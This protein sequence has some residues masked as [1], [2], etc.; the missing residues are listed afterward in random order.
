MGDFTRRSLIKSLGAAGAASLFGPLIL[1]ATVRAKASGRV[2]VIGGGFGGATCAKYARRYAPGI[3]VTLVERGAKYV[4]CPFS[5]TVLGGLNDMDFITHGYDKLQSK[6]GIK[7]VNDTVT[8]VDPAA[9]K[10]ELKGGKSLSYD[11]LVVSPGIAFRW[12]EIEG[13][14]EAASE[15]MPHAWKAGPQTVL[16]RKQIEAM[17]DGG[18]VI[19][20]PPAGPF[21]APSAPYERASMIAYYLK[22]NKPKSKVLIVDSRD[23]FDEK[24]QFKGAWEKLYPGMIELVRASYGG[25]VQKADPSTMTV[26]AKAGES[27]K[28]NVINVIPPQRAGEIAHAAGLVDDDGWCPVD[29]KTFESAK[30]K[31]IHVIGDS[32]IAGDMPKAASA[33]STQGK[34]CA[35]AIVSSLSG[36]PMPDPLHASVFYSLLDKRYGISN[37]HLYRL[38]DGR[39]KVVSGGPSPEKASKKFRRREAE[40]ANSWYAAI[41]ADTFG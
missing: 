14:D 18:V 17:E 36:T 29:Q 12:G 25:M 4:T 11:Y 7:L 21:R 15:V 1:P 31:G 19:I 24:A 3:D 26:I 2:V 13:Y 38:V 22:E 40:F 23:E 27:Y 30:H 35:A 33:A 16:L 39:I 20:A 6:H 8:A 5:N 32:C 10:V 28:G 9:K 34:A 37:A 41:T